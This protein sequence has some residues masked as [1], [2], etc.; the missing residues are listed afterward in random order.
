[1]SASNR[2]LVIVA[3]V[4]TVAVLA[5]IAITVLASGER[6]YAEGTPERAVQDYL[7][8]VNDRDAT[9]AMTYLAPALTERCKFEREPIS[10]RSTR[11]IR[12]TLERTTVRDS[13][14]EVRVRLTEAYNSDSPFGSGEYTHTQVFVL[15]QVQGQWR[16][17]DPP[18]PLY[19][20][21][22]PVK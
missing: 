8:A 15:T 19:C 7:R 5:G 16:F 22:T 20:P 12:A 11:S 17:V 6:Q 13:T 10:N 2:W 14:A 18:W 3:G 9:T 21:P 1:V 4:V